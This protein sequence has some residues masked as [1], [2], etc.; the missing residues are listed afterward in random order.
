MK[1][2][3]PLTS[4]YVFAIC[5]CVALTAPLHA[6]EQPDKAAAQ[7]STA[8]VG[9]K[10][11][12]ATHQAQQAVA[13][14]KHKVTV[15][16]TNAD[17]NRKKAVAGGK[18]KTGKHQATINEAS[19]K[20]PKKKLVKKETAQA[21]VGRVDFKVLK[22]RLKGTDAIGFFTKLAI[23]NDIVDLMDKIKQ[24][25]KRSILKANMKKIRNSF[26]GLLL[27]IIA[28]LEKDPNLSRDLYVGRE[29]IWESLLEVKA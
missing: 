4:K 15:K 16:K 5:A 22:E 7:A 6:C 20:M 8:M 11:T 19:E 1:K 9:G 18:S 13:K 29:S 12:L 26:D 28:L 21:K 25:R 17:N 10:S 14:T 23:R 3:I 2:I 24:Y 27:K